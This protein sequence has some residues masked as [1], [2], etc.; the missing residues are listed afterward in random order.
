VHRRL[1]GLLVLLAT[2]LP[3]DAA[4][5]GDPIMPLG[6]V[7]A[8]MQCT[9]YSVVRGTD[10][11][12]FD[13]EVLDV[14]DS[15]AD[16][17]YLLV[18][19]SGPAVDE[20]GIGPGFSGSPIYCP[21]ADGVARNAGA[22]SASLGQYGGKVVLATPI[23]AILGTPPEPPR[24][25]AS[26]R[27][28]GRVRP[29]AT[30]LVASGLSGPVAR[31]LEREGAKAGRQVLAAPAGPLG[32]FAAPPLRPGS[33]M[34]ASYASGDLHLGAVGTVAYVD[35][36]RVWGFGHPFESAGTRSLMLQDAYV[37]RVIDNPNP[38]NGGSY[39]LAAP[40]RTVGTL[41][42]DEVSAVAGVLGRMP[43][44]VPV[45]VRVAD[46]DRGGRKEL[47]VDVADETEVGS[48]T[49]ANLPFVAPLAVLQG[50]TSVLR[51]IPPRSTIRY[52]TRISVRELEE[53]LR[54][55]NRAV[56]AAGIGGQYDEE[57]GAAGVPAYDLLSALL[58]IEQH[59]RAPLH[60]TGVEVDASVTREPRLLELV[61]V[62]APRRVRAGRRI[63][64]RLR[65]RPARG[66]T[67]TIR[68]PWRVPSGARRGT[69]SLVIRASDTRDASGSFGAIVEE[70]DG[71]PEGS[72]NVP[73][74]EITSA[75]EAL[76]AGYDGLQ[77][78]FAG[79]VRHLYRDP[80]WRIEGRASV[81]LRVRR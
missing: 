33:A 64:L 54:Y 78:R 75:V 58:L 16:G 27:L 37:F 56:D 29:L 76:D 77:A 30:P 67:R 34:A 23:E 31:A 51:S 50:A 65:V 10:V 8:G 68:V 6:D 15:G 72:G 71:G 25:A 70:M 19:A 40:G 12:A 9:G 3:A 20:T 4:L 44:T 46:L 38:E 22:I 5:A 55:C 61:S 7:R 17:P 14:V 32:S 2:F 43:A 74:E 53:P 66:R 47:S 28:R 26:S 60:V 18:R 79:R 35:G 48:P 21:G 39:K 24:A 45:K 13:V 81:R 41:T 59:E 63:T 62:S 73:L 52:C 69:R 80:E 57:F 42:A 1:T 11:S 49:G 36:N